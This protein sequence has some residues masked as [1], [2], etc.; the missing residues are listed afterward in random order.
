MLV[1][2][3]TLVLLA[4]L[5][6]GIFTEYPDDMLEEEMEA[7]TMSSLIGPIAGIAV[8]NIVDIILKAFGIS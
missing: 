8:I 1:P 4:F 6:R 7:E 2:L 3:L 5:V